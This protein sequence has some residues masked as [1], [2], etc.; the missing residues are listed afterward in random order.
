MDSDTERR[1]SAIEEKQRDLDYKIGQLIEFAR[2][3]KGG[4]LILQFLGLA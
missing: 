2:L 1:L 4:R 3:T